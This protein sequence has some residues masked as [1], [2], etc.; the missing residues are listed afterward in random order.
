[1]PIL[2]ILGNATLS[3]MNKVSSGYW[4][5]FD[6][7]N[8]FTAISTRLIDEL[9]IEKISSRYFFES[10]M[11]FRLG[12]LRAVIL[13]IPMAAIYAD[14]KSGL[15]ISRS[16]YDFLFGHIANSFKRIFYNYYLRGFSVA[17]IEL[18]F[19]VI[20]ISFGC[21][22]GAFHWLLSIMSGVPASTGTVMVAALPVIVGFQLLISFLNYDIASAPR[23][24]I[25]PL[26]GRPD[27]K[28]SQ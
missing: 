15:S 13:D 10:D 17:S 14:E 20:A 23:T 19:G 6:P 25:H 12:T 5:V 3:F 26:M 9:P 4:S 24:A 22:F 27:T 21:V 7:T 18:F 28:L 8:G 1:M 2:R 11:L 16:V